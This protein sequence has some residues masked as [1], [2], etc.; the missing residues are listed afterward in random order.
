MAVV[1]GEDLLALA[2]EDRLARLLA[3]GVGLWDVIQDAVREGS[4]DA[5]IRDHSG[6]DLR[7]LVARLPAL[8]AVAF[9]GG[10]SAKIGRRLLGDTPLDL[11]ALPSSSPAYTLALAAKAEAWNVLKGYLADKFDCSRSG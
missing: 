1:I 3:H 5:A 8:R 2:Y 11:I 10:T 7:S 4:L 9:N 6:N